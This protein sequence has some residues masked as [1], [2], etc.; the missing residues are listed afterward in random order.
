MKLG[1][2]VHPYFF[3][4]AYVAMALRALALLCY[5]LTRFKIVATRHGDFS[6][7]RLN[8]FVDLGRG[9]RGYFVACLC[10]W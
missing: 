5:R 3:L 6:T 9:N 2:I 7:I 4:L 8:H 10:R 1:K